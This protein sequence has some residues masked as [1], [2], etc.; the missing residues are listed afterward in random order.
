LSN[1]LV[2]RTVKFEGE[3]LMMWGCMIWDGIGYATKLDGETKLYI[4]ILGDELMKTVKFYG[5]SLE[6]VIFQQ[7]NDPKQC[8]E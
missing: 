4:E 7:K 6:E 2:E 3:N 1:R 5:Y 8:S